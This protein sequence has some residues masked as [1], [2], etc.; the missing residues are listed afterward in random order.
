M[1]EAS[2][3]LHEHRLG[4]RHGSAFRGLAC[5]PG[6]PYCGKE[7]EQRNK[8]VKKV[9]MAQCSKKHGSSHYNAVCVDVNIIDDRALRA[10]LYTRHFFQQ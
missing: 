6:P 4:L 3:V 8:G 10:A 5:R 7:S 9:C 2:T 1:A